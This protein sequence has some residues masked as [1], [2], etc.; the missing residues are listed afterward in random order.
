LC[1][2]EDVRS[3]I[4]GQPNVM[5]VSHSPGAGIVWSSGWTVADSVPMSV[6]RPLSCN[7][8]GPCTT[9]NQPTS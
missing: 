4:L 7:S 9:G 5:P 8:A 3:A 2:G 6:R 1:G